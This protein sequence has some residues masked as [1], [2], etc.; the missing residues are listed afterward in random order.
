[1]FTAPH[2]GA[3]IVD[4]HGGPT[5]FDEAFARFSER[6]ETGGTDRSGSYGFAIHEMTEA[7]DIRMGMLG[8]SN[9]PAHHIPFFPMFTGR[10]DDAHRIVRECLDRL[11]V[12]SDLGQGYPGDE[13]NGEMSA[14]YVFA[15]IG[16]Y[17]LAPSTGTYVLV[18]PSVRRTVLRP[19]G[20]WFAHRHRD[21][22]YRPVHRRRHGRRRAVG[23]HQHPARGGGRGVADR[24]RAVGDA[25]RVGCGHAPDLGVRAARVP[26]HPGRRPA[27]RGLTAHGRHRADPGGTRRGGRASWCRSR[28]RRHRSSR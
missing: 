21:H 15:T 16:L 8:L 3:G 11:F 14:W 5:A 4:L 25:G 19:P 27:G 13:D 10:H 26:G 23:V 20:E 6:R 24:R 17:P 28:S 1:M 2:D 18:P 7:R 12:G 9:Q 22:R